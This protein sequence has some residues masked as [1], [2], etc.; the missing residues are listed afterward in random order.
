MEVSK[1]AGVTD[2]G[3][4][5]NGAN[6]IIT[7]TIKIE[8][9]GNVS[10]SN[11]LLQDNLRDGN[12]NALSINGPSLTSNTAGS[13]TATLLT[14]GTLTFT[15]SYTIDQNAANT[16]LIVNTASVTASSPN[17]TNDI[18]GTDSVSVTTSF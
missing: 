2:N 16:S 15:A 6:D 8:N 3:D 10:L 14:N 9:K 12:N 17:N 7:Y 13:S 4:G 18:T 11:I 1:T 5:I